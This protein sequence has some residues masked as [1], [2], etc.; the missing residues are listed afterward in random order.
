MLCPRGADLFVRRELPA[1][2]FGQR[3]VQVGFFLG[4][5]FVRWLLNARELQE[6]AGKLILH[7]LGE[8]ADSL[9]GLFKEAGHRITLAKSPQQQA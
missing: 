5:E 4:R 6:H 2:S 9:N 7:L 8:N 3:S 1:L